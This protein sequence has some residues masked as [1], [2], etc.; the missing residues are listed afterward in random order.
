MVIEAAKELYGRG[1]IDT[2]L[3]I[4]PAAVRISWADP[5]FGE[6]QKWSSDSLVKV[7][8][9]EKE[10]Y[11]T[12][13]LHWL[14][15]SYEFA[16]DHYKWLVSLLA[17]RRV[18]VVADESIKIKSPKAKTTKALHKLSDQAA[19]RKVVLNG[20]PGNMMDCWGQYRF[21]GEEAV[22]PYVNFYG[23]WR[24]HFSVWMTRP[25]PKLIKFIN[26]ED[27]VT[28]TKPR[29]LMRPKSS[30]L[31]PQIYKTAAV[32]LDDK[33]WRHY[34]EMKEEM[35]TWLEKQPSVASNVG[36]QLMR[37]QQI[38]S[39]YI[40]GVDG[41]AKTFSSEKIDWAADWLK[42]CLEEDP[43]FRCIFWCQF[44]SEIHRLEE[45]INGIAPTSLIIGGQSE[46]DRRTS[47]Q[48]FTEGTRAAVLI[49]QP[50]AGGYGLNLVRAHHVIFLSRDYS[51]INREQ[52]EDRSHR[53]G[54]TFP[55][56]YVDVL[57]EGPTGQRTIDHV[58]LKALKSKQDLYK[59]TAAG[60]LKELKDAR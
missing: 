53:I 18:L 5:E 6:I 3:V 14:V 10:L 24:P 38:T 60:W 15:C 46:S 13:T 37:L 32:T 50:H 29:T 26:H 2:V 47:I 39:G 49:G 59:W 28:L 27:F 21:L 25:F 44:R 54:Q 40:G 34:R 43:E 19:N 33:T 23:Q 35:I 8:R 12:G 17:H 9:S 52:A 16:R 48:Q 20:T 36:V 58:V 11:F 1:E 45:A 42:E 56:T 41:E 30:A 51:Q 55:V 31:P 22:K 4:C 7:L 57:A